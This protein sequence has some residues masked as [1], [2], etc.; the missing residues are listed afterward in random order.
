M[1]VYFSI[2]PMFP[3][4]FEIKLGQL[5]EEGEMEI[6]ICKGRGESL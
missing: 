4:A 3:I 6:W 2:F 5:T 1:L